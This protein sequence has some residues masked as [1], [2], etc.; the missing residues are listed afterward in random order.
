[1][2]DT[3]V[4]PVTHIPYF[5]VHLTFMMGLLE[6]ISMTE[7]MAERGTNFFENEYVNHLHYHYPVQHLNSPAMFLRYR[8]VWCTTYTSIVIHDV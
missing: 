4:R 2:L 6:T 1:M 3:E 5:A 7:Q 8:F